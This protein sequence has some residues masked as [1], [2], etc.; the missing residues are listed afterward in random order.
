MLTFH[1]CDVYLQRAGVQLPT[2][3]VIAEPLKWIA[4]MAA[5]RVT[6]SWAPNFGFK[7]VVAAARASGQ[8]KLSYDVACI[9]YLM[10]AGEQVTGEACDAFAAVCGLAPRVLQP[11][12][13][14][15]ECCTCMTY[16][17][18]YA[19][20]RSI[21]KVLKS[22]L[23]QSVL[24]IDEAP[25]GA[26]AVAAHQPFVM[27]GVVSPGVEIRICA[28]GHVLN[29]LQVGRFQIRGPCVMPGYHNHPKANAE[30]I[31]DDG[32]MD[33]GDLGFVYRGELVLTGRA[34][35]M[36]CVGGEHTGAWPCS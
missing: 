5:Y 25:A 22:T 13:G 6:H 16:H 28:D 8:A 27:L 33:S 7:L 2:A 10:N 20:G 31:L 30:S 3:E 4:T 11:A 21:V 23:Q 34:K 14:M 1:L 18:T 17:N 24:A 29:E 35:E 9:K 19:P 36:M 26:A 12:F 32:W 15:A